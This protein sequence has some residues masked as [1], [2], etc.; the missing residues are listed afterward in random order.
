MTKE[1][2]LTYIN[3]NI[4]TNGN[5][6][7]TGAILNPVLTAIVNQIND[8]V[9]AKANLPDGFDNVISALSNVTDNTINFF[10]GNDSPNDT[11]PADFKTGD[12]QTQKQGGVTVGFWQYNGIIWVEVL[13]RL[14]QKLRNYVIVKD[15]YVASYETDDIIVYRGSNVSDTMDLPDATSSEGKVF[16][17]VN[18]ADHDLDMLTDYLTINS[19]IEEKDTIDSLTAITVVSDGLRWQQINN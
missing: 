13:S 16:T 18:A 11:H 4:T 10:S 6:E 12:F 3:D 8:L 7:I 2:V 9:G 14:E 1:Q 5:N 17:I 15:S 19:S